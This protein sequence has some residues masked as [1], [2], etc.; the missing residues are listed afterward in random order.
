MQQNDTI[1]PL[2]TCVNLGR[3]LGFLETA[4]ADVSV[5]K[6]SVNSDHIL[7][8]KGDDSGGGNR[9]LKKRRRW[10]TAEKGK[11]LLEKN[12]QVVRSEGGAV[13]DRREE[14]MW[15]ELREVNLMKLESL[16][17]LLP[18]KTQR[19]FLCWNL[20]LKEVL[21]GWRYLR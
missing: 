1:S 13:S 12:G 9:R 6:K 20:W 8:K 4:F 10:T 17:Q 2:F 3:F 18:P 15:M 21:F 19:I 16:L 11:V 7:R 5:P 14:Q